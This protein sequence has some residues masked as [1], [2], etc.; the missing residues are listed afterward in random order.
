MNRWTNGL[1]AESLNGWSNESRAGWMDGY[2]MGGCSNGW[3]DGFG[4]WVAR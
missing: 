3:L 1:I 2:S 4:G